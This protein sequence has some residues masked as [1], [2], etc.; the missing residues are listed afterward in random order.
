MN[1]Y[2]ERRPWGRFEQFALNQKCTVKLHYINPNQKWSLQTHEKRSEFFKIVSGE[3]R[4]TV[5]EKVV[6]AKPGDEFEVPVGAS[7][8]IEAKEELVI[9]FELT[10]DEF[11]ENDIKR[12][13]D[14][15]DRV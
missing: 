13:E 2:T 12:I 11:D 9:I 5:G 1:K 3:A 7:H 6:D 10:F 15:Y 4:V 14:A 8:R